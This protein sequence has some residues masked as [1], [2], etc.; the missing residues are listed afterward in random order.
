[1]KIAA[2][3]AESKGLLQITIEDVKQAVKG[4][5]KYRL[6]YL[7]KKL[8]EHQRLIYEILKRKLRMGSGELYEQYSK[9]SSEPVA[10]RVYRNYMGRMV[11]LGLI[12][13]EGSG[14]W[15]VY[16]IVT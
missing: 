7:L 14:R 9:L 6:S 1:M 5:R 8:N 13:A 15:K 4:A 10:D 2:R 11:E 12:K 16:E 3:N